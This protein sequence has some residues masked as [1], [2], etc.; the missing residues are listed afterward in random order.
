MQCLDQHPPVF[1]EE[2]VALGNPAG[3][4]PMLGGGNAELEQGDAEQ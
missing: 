1:V 3:Q 4:P 2:P